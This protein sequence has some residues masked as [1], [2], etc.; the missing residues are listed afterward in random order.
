MIFSL[1]NKA[2]RCILWSSLF[3]PG[4]EAQWGWESWPV[5][6]QWWSWNQ[7][8]S[9]FCFKPGA[10]PTLVYHRKEG[11]TWAWRPSNHYL[12]KSEQKYLCFLWWWW[13][14]RRS[15]PSQG[16][17]VSLCPGGR[18]SCSREPPEG[19]QGL[20][21]ITLWVASFSLEQWQPLLTLFSFASNSLFFPFHMKALPIL[22]GL[23]SD[24]GH[25]KT[26]PLPLVLNFSHAYHLHTVARFG[27]GPASGWLLL[28]YLW[29]GW[30]G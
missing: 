25:D 1:Y 21:H 23:A 28:W 4:T 26:H 8:T 5:V 6:T 22:Q 7:N 15:I 10:L 24:T 3:S 20:L 11:I 29:A 9:L 27:H 12:S 16:P 17:W 30:P 18:A 13:M 19:L 14:C 2:A